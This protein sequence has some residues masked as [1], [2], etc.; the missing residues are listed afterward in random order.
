MRLSIVAL[1]TALGIAAASQ[2]QGRRPDGYEIQNAQRRLTDLRAELENVRMRS[3]ELVRARITHDLQIHVA[4]LEDLLP[5]TSDLIDR[6]RAENEKELREV[7]MRIERL[8]TRLHRAQAQGFVEPLDPMLPKKRTESK[9][10]P[11][12]KPAQPFRESPEVI[13]E[14]AKVPRA[15]VQDEMDLRIPPPML[16]RN[17]LFLDAPRFE[18]VAATH[19]IK[20]IRALLRANREKDALVA[21]ERQLIEEPDSLV[22]LFLKARALE[23]L[24]RRSAARSLYEKVRELDTHELDDGRENSS[25]EVKSGPWARAAVLALKYLDRMEPY[26]DWQPPSLEALDW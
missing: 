23:K 21:V 25:V 18:L 7:S 26:R 1:A 9:A 4:N 17:Q 6:P 20:G 10:E 13:I 8:S 24:G 19:P 16:S 12:T 15:T 11:S 5:E 14:L 2:A 3:A 22:H